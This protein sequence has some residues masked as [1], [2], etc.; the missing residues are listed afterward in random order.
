MKEVNTQRR[1]LL[2]LGAA[3]ITGFSSSP[4]LQAKPLRRWRM[5]VVPQLTPV[6]IVHAWAPIIQAL[7]EAGVACELLT[8]PDIAKFEVE[9]M[10][11]LADF[12]YLN[13]YHMVMAQ[14]RHGYHALLHDKQALEGL[15]LCQADGPYTQIEQLR[16]QIIAFPSPNAFAASLYMRALL[17]RQYHLRF[18]SNYAQ[19]HRNALRQV[20]T[21][22]AAA[23]GVISKTFASET[24][25][26]QERLRILLRTPTVASHPI[27]AHPRV[28]GPVRELFVNTLLGLGETA[29]GRGMLQ[30]IN[31][32]QPVRAN[33]VTDY[34]PLKQL[35]LERYVVENR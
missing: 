35:Q 2:R 26:V 3:G 29:T 1:R 6:E 31:M 25:E 16:D 27:A 7:S 15:L 4:Y 12:V 18:Q 19:N 13:P 28:P 30:A 8:Y 10:R 21:G 24:P 11:G 33:Y 17:E 34:A 14:Q 9:F 20:L 32:P 5:A 23:C 22:D